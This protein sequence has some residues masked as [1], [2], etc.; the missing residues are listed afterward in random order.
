[1]AVASMDHISW[2][3]PPNGDFDLKEAYKLASMHN[4]SPTMRLL[5]VIGSGNQSLCLKSG[6]SFGSVSIE[7]YQLE[8]CL[9]SRA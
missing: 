6:A 4:D 3:S 7:V 8:R 9:S 5:L 1:M 2:A